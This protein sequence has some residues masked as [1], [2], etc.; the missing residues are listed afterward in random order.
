VVVGLVDDALEPQASVDRPR[1][2]IDPEGGPVSLETG[3]PAAAGLEA[4]GHAVH[5]GISGFGRAHFGRGQV[6]LRDPEG[7]LRGG[8]DPRADG[9]VARA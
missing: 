1:F 5:A 7:R 8:S 3:F 4:R 2:C 9:G 6:I